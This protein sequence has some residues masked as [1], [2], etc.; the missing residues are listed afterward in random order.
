LI[1]LVRR[2][3]VTGGENDAADFGQCFFRGIVELAVIDIAF[4]G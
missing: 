4:V 2:Q 3:G 1:D